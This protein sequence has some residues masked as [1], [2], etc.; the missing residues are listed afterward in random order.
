MNSVFLQQKKKRFWTCL[1]KRTIIK[2]KLTG[3]KILNNQKA[4]KLLIIQIQNLNLNLNQ[5]TK[6][7]KMIMKV[8]IFKKNK[9]QKKMKLIKNYHQ[10]KNINKNTQKIWFMAEIFSKI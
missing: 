10:I 1:K 4:A 9:K 7:M 8:N 6:I 5:K 2:S 3:F